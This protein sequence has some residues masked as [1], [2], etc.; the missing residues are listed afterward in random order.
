MRT[1]PIPPSDSWP[2]RH[3]RIHR[4]SDKSPKYAQSKNLTLV[5]G[6]FAI[7]VKRPREL[8][9][10]ERNDWIHASEQGGIL[11]A[12]AGSLVLSPVGASGLKSPIATD[13]RERKSLK[14][15]PMTN[16]LEPRT[17]LPSI[18]QTLQVSSEDEVVTAVAV[19]GIAVEGKHLAR[20][21]L[22]RRWNNPPSL[23]NISFDE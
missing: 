4:I 15:D 14:L 22:C 9:I 2:D 11:D 19:F 5:E 12:S 10:L 8:F 13:T 7:Q 1:T 20:Q 6:G 18:K 3:I 16:L 17:I 21:D 23:T